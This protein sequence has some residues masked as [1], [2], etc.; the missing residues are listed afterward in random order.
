MAEQYKK[1]LEEISYYIGYIE[2]FIIIVF[3]LFFI[4]NTLF[5]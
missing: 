4:E 2:T 5:L 1:I 3:L